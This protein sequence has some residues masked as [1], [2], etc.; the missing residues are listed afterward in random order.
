MAV[1]GFNTDVFFTN[2]TAEV[3]GLPVALARAGGIP[4]VG[5]HK[6]RKASQVATYY[7]VNL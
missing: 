7:Y 4:P 3:P 5:L 2:D 1:I 6:I